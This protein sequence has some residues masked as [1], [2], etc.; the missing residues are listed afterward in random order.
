MNTEQLLTSL[1]Q[2]MRTHIQLPDGLAWAPAAAAAVTLVFGLITV[3]RGARWA[4]GLMATGFSVLGGVGGYLLAG[5]IATPPWLAAA[6]VA[7]AGGVIGVLFFRI[8]QA[9]LL[10]CAAMGLAVGVFAVQSLTPEIHAWTQGAAPDDVAFELRPAGSVV[11]D[12]QPGMGEQVASLWEHLGANVPGFRAKLVSV[13]VA[14]GLAGLI[15]GLLLPRA[16][17]ALWV[18][19]SGTLMLGLGA[20]G[21][22][23]QF[24]PARIDWLVQNPHWG[25]AGLG[26]VWVAAFAYALS[27]VRVRPPKPQAPK[28]ASTPPAPAAA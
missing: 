7:V 5:Q 13:L 25:W 22:L 6:I 10:A 17:R 14:S 24:A 1:A 26:L 23:Q 15:F 20:A 21:L 4:P 8:W 3:M 16:S 18:S 11:G 27:T 9:G 19:S 28:A 2:M 12:Q